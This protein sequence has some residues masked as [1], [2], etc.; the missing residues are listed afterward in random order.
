MWRSLVDGYQSF[1]GTYC[2]HRL[3]KQWYIF[4]YQNDIISQKNK[5]S[6]SSKLLKIKV[7][8]TCLI[9]D[10]STCKKKARD[11]SSKSNYYSSLKLV[12]QMATQNRY[13]VSIETFNWCSKR[14]IEY[15]YIENLHCY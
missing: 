14:N 10:S 12:L 15:L 8:L 13:L 5:L 3:P 2:F 9:N 1:V 4:T 7:I 6:P 11:I